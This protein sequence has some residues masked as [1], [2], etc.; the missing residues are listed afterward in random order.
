MSKSQKLDWWSTSY[1][2]KERAELVAKVVGKLERKLSSKHD[3]MRKNLQVYEGKRISSLSPE[4]YH[5]AT[6]TEGGR[7]NAAQSAADS[8]RA[9]LF[10]NAGGT[11]FKPHEANPHLRKRVQDLSDFCE[12]LI[13]NAGL[14]GMRFE[15]ILNDALV[16]G[17]GIWRVGWEVPDAQSKRAD[18]TVVRVLPWH[19]LYNPADCENGEAPGELYICRLVPREQLYETYKNKPRIVEKIKTLKAATSPV[20][21]PAC[22][23]P[24]TDEIHDKVRV[25]ECYRRAPSRT[26]P[27]AYALIAVDDAEQLDFRAYHH[28]LFPI[29][30]FPYAPSSVGWVLEAQSFV[31]RVRDLQRDVDE[32]GEKIRDGFRMAPS[33]LVPEDPNL[34]PP[35]KLTNEL[36]LPQLPAGFRIEH[37]QPTTQWHLNY[38]RSKIDAVYQ[39]SGVSQ[40]S[41]QAQKPA[42]I[43]AAVALQA[44]EDAE[45]E[46]FYSV[47][48]RLSQFWVDLSL[49][50][51]RAAR[52]ATLAGMRVE[53]SLESGEWVRSLDFRSFNLEDHQFSIYPQPVSSKPRSYAAQL[54]S[55]SQALQNGLMDM[56]EARMMLDLPDLAESQRIQDA[57]MTAVQSDVEDILS[58]GEPRTP[59]AKHDDLQYA[60]TYARA[61]YLLERRNRPG[62]KEHAGRLELLERYIDAAEQA[63]KAM[64]P[65]P[66]APEMIPDGADPAAVAGQ[67]ADPA[68]VAA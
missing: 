57:A 41:A 16:A 43:D 67:P 35:K 54:S 22:K 26:R 14:R 28:T 31:E 9:K 52:D 62:D 63:I 47:S 46:R 65:P 49:A 30:A 12:G 2:P 20:N 36:G 32:T 53:A 21:T 51:I 6:R 45:T 40:L 10:R 7:E 68:A 4:S 60:V 5:E 23:A 39:F 8:L 25:I 24:A 37:G 29:A 19:I 55:A 1:K 56:R 42:G 38:H 58:D 3:E 18:I 15:Q 34:T 13:V 33:I 59:S 50:M 48:S 66:P 64:A 27:G 44:L 17:T 61:R 11:V